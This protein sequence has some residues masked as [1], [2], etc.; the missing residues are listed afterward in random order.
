MTTPTCSVCGQGGYWV[1][2]VPKVQE[3]RCVNHIDP[4]TT[5]ELDEADLADI[6]QEA[7]DHMYDWEERPRAMRNRTR[8]RQFSRS[9]FWCS[10]CSSWGW[11]SALARPTASPQFPD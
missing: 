3:Y 2:W 8:A 4:V 6:E 9:A 7:R 5:P 1:G 10:W 11:R